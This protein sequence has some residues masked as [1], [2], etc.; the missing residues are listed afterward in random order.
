MTVS[1]AYWL[2]IPHSGHVSVE[3]ANAII[4]QSFID[5][6][7]TTWNNGSMREDYW[8][9]TLVK[10]LLISRKRLMIFDLRWITCN[11]WL[12]TIDPL[13][14]EFDSKHFTYDYWIVWREFYLETIDT[15]MLILGGTLLIFRKYLQGHDYWPVDAIIDH[16]ASCLARIATWR[17]AVHKTKQVIQSW[18]VSVGL[19]SEIVE[20]CKFNTGSTRLGHCSWTA[21]IER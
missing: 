21:D 2:E 7:C 15:R 20:L 5:N 16:W 12:D 13:S 19:R 6:A 11:T 9:S 3:S 4:A 8:H 1:V 14:R 10:W 17:Q 18:Q